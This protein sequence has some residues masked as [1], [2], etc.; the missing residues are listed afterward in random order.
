MNALKYTGP[1]FMFHGWCCSFPGMMRPGRGGGHSLPSSLLGKNEW[2]YAFTPHI[3][4]YGLDMASFAFYHLTE[5]LLGTSIRITSRNS[6]TILYIAG[7]IVLQHTRTRGQFHILV[8][9]LLVGNKQHR[10]LA[11]FPSFRA[12]TK[13]TSK[14][15]RAN[16]CFT[17]RSLCLHAEKLNP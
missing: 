2:S 4:L 3:S 8:C 5:I 9:F 10:E 14:F 12:N 15:T 11:D 16:T 13:M 6:T 1:H 7:T 17:R